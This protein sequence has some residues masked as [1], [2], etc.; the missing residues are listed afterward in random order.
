MVTIKNE[1]DVADYDTVKK[2]DIAEYAQIT[3]LYSNFTFSKKG[4]EIDR[5]AGANGDKLKNLIE[6]H[7]EIPEEGENLLKFTEKDYKENSIIPLKYVEFQYVSN[8]VAC[9]LIHYK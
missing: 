5:L 3:A 6:H 1:D 2:E 8:I 7:I 9:N 4:Q